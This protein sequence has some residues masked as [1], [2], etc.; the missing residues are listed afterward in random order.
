MWLFPWLT[1]AA[2]AFIAVVLVLMVVL[3]GQRLELLLSLVLTAV[4]VLVGVRHQRAA[5]AVD[6]SDRD[7]TAER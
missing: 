2:L 6:V 7:V 3:P 1:Y 4:V 5:R